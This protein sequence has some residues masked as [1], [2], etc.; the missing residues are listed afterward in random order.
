MLYPRLIALLTLLVALSSAVLLSACGG[1]PRPPMPPAGTP[2]VGVMVVQPRQVA[3]STELPGRTAPFQIAEVR[4]QVSGL[5][6][7]R[8]FREGS[9][10]RAGDKLYQIDP[11]SYKAS[12]DSAVASAAKAEASLLSARLKADRNRELVAIKAIS[13]QDAEDSTA[14]LQQAQADLA[15]AK[16]AVETAR[17]NLAYTQVTSP[18][19]GRIG[20]SSVTTGALVTANQSTA[21]ATVQQLDPIYVDVTQST[22]A[23]LRLKQALARGELKAP[24]GAGT[25]SGAGSSSG[26][27]VRVKL[28]LEDGSAY[29]LEGRLQ[30]SEATVDTTS[31]AITL[32]A[33]FPNPKGDLL[34]GMYVRAVVEEGVNEAALLVP[35][36]AVSRDATGKPVAYVVGP[37]NKLQPRQLVTDQAVGDQWLVRS[38]L[39]PG[40]QLVVDGQ[41]SARPGVTVETV[42]W[43]PP[44]NGAATSDAGWGKPAGQ[45]PAPTPAPEPAPAPA[46]R[47]V[48]AAKP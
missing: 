29:P 35:Q 12:W 1:P 31:G 22:A 10:L 11:A 40:D 41:Q 46:V 7:S 17:I 15:S 25:G 21:L 26:A 9:D 44:A 18:I 14:S 28:L 19:A 5:I 38:G 24:S 37:D 23:L 36:A 2:K 27:A 45:A 39:Q 32:R 33:L 42:A 3:I 34:P 16:A 43:V 13:Q 20:R 30:F 48:A 4:P 6:Q 8:T 47:K